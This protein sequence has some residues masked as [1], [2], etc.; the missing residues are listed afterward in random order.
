V[1]KHLDLELIR[2]NPK[3]FFGYSDNTNLHMFLFN[4][5]VVSYH[6][7]AVITKFAGLTF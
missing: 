1:L 7:S 3:P 5:G 6:R 2:A 4:L